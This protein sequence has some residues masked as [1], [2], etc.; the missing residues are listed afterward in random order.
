MA[1]KIFSANV[2]VIFFSSSVL[3]LTGTRLLVSANEQKKQG[4][5]EIANKQKRAGT[6]RGEHLFKFVNP[7]S[8]WSTS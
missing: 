7:L 8:T 5:S 1:I 2:R 3:V 4:S 6:E